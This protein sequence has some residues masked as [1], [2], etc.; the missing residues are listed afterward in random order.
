MKTE[1]QS[2]EAHPSN[3]FD[4]NEAFWEPEIKM[5]PSSFKLREIIE[6]PK[7]FYSP[8]GLIQRLLQ[9]WAEDR[10]NEYLYDLFS[11]ASSKD[12]FILA[13]L[14]PIIEG[15]E[16]KLSETSDKGEIN[17]LNENLEYFKGLYKRGVRYLII[18]GQHR[19]H[20]IKKYF[21]VKVNR[22]YTAPTVSKLSKIQKRLQ[23]IKVAN[24]D[25]IPETFVMNKK[26]WNE[27]PRNL[28]ILLLDEIKIVVT[29]ITSGDIHELK[30]LF[31]KSNSG[32][33]LPFFVA[34]LSDSYG[35]TW[36]YMT[37]LCDKKTTSDN[38]LELE[39]KF[40]GFA[41]AY[42]PSNM[43]LAY[44]FSEMLCYI[45][46]KYGQDRTLPLEQDMK[47]TLEV[48]YDFEFS[49]LDKKTRELHSKILKIIGNGMAHLIKKSKGVGRADFA[50][51]LIMTSML[52]D[53]KHPS[54]PFK[55]GPKYIINDS[56][57]YIEEV[58]KMLVILKQADFW[59]VSPEGKEV[60]RPNLQGN[61]V[62]AK[63]PDSYKEHQRAIWDAG[64]V[65]HRED[66]MWTR[67]T[68]EFLPTLEIQNVISRDGKAV[69]N[70]TEK[71]MEVAVKRDFEDKYGEPLDV[72]DD[73]LGHNKRHDL[74]HLIAKSKGG[75]DSVENLQYEYTSANRSKG[76]A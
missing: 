37:E 65:R 26:S 7:Q 53:N 67:F 3:P 4:D 15:L 69:T 47:N 34:L 27:V 59:M 6:D 36:R 35:V 60:W 40:H 50:D 29:M 76:N 44:L 19:I 46:S 21:Q 16:T 28:Q 64:N 57:R 17:T 8:Q 30:G 70:Q 72:F 13:A 58:M 38:I 1:E 54:R 12:L 31:R 43:G 20:E 66:M 41:G 52:L 32:T 71:R 24:K 48:L 56:M 75:N 25:G 33:P 62:R 74:G 51:M 39:N 42:A 49:G 18:D 23:G 68:E 45:A 9:E 11:G 55:N 73:V 61:T 10:R 22:P 63:N 14:E 2:L 5:Y